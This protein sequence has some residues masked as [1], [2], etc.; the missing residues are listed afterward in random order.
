MASACSSSAGLDI[1]YG[2]QLKS[3]K[4]VGVMLPA[5]SCTHAASAI[6]ILLVNGRQPP[7]AP[8]LPLLQMHRKLS[9]LSIDGHMRNFAEGNTVSAAG[10]IKRIARGDGSRMRVHAGARHRIYVSF[11]YGMLVVGVQLAAETKEGTWLQNNGKLCRVLVLA[12]CDF[13]EADAGRPP[14]RQDGD[15]RLEQ[16]PVRMRHDATTRVVPDAA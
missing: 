2:S 6:G 16:R 13:V 10:A 15:A 4:N 8:P 3:E 12:S 1:S 11:G 7:C 9:L 14:E 5:T